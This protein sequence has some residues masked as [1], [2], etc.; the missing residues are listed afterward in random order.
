MRR[1][2]PDPDRAAVRLPRW[3]ASLSD[4]GVQ[5]IG[6]LALLVIAGFVMLGLAWRGAAR[7]IYVPLQLPWF[8]SGSLL[9]L[10]CI[11]MG[12]GAWSI[13]LGRRQDAAHRDAVETLVRDAVG[14]AEEMRNSRAPLPPR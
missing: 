11:G 14:L 4:A 6:V 13:H 2:E 8:A 7:T 3:A 12:L 1:R 5:A 9:G 10:A